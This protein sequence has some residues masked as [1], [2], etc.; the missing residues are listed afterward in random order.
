MPVMPDS[1]AHQIIRSMRDTAI[2]DTVNLKRRIDELKAEFK[3]DPWEITEA[4]IK[5]LETRLE[6]RV[7]EATALAIATVQFKEEGK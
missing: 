5:R 4:Q 3:K 7:K 6:K 2:E 1:E